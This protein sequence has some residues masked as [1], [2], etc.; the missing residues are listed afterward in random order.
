LHQK[1]A[2]IV[3][4]PIHQ[5]HTLRES[6]ESLP[7]LPCDLLNFYNNIHQDWRLITAESN[8]R[9]VIPPLNVNPNC[10]CYHYRNINWTLDEWTRIEHASSDKHYDFEMIHLELIERPRYDILS[11]DRSRPPYNM[12]FSESSHAFMYISHVVSYFYEQFNYVKF[13]LFHKH[14]YWANEYRGPCYVGLDRLPLIK[15][16]YTRLVANIQSFQPNASKKHS[17][18]YTELLTPITVLH[19]QKEK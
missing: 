14:H 6:V 4:I 5:Q 2:K 12:F 3:D 8:A 10:A 16:F 19:S 13:R 17:L 1:G 18:A 9:P 15:Q 7:L 11:I